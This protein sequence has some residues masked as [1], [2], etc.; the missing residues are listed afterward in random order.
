MDLGEQSR[1]RARAWTVAW[2]AAV[3]LF[4]AYAAT[5]ALTGGAAAEWLGDAVV[6]TGAALAV[7]GALRRRTARA[8]LGLLAA[9]LVLWAAGQVV[10][11]LAYS[12]S[13]APP[14]PSW[15]DACRL[16]CYP[17]YYLSLG[18]LAR[19]RLRRLPRGAWLDGV[20][21]ALT[22]AAFAVGILLRPLRE[23]TGGSLPMVA[24][25][26]A[27]PIGDV[28]LLVLML[29]VVVLGGG[30]PGRVWAFLGAG[31]LLNVAADW[32]FIFTAR[33]GGWADVVFAAAVLCL[34]AATWQ[35][36]TPAARTVTAGWGAV[37]GPIIAM[38][39]ALSLLGSWAILPGAHFAA[40]IPAYAAALLGLGRTMLTVRE[41]LQLVESRREALTDELTGLANRRRLLR[42]LDA[43]LAAPGGACTLMLVD[44]DGFKALNDSLGHAAGDRVLAV[45][46]ARLRRAV[47]ESGLVARLGGDEFAVLLAG[48]GDA[49]PVAQALH[50]AIARPLPLAGGPAVGASIGL[51]SAPAHGDHP[52]TL[53]R[54]ADLAMYAAKRTGAATAVAQRAPAGTM[55]PELRRALDHGELE[56][57]VQPQARLAD[58]AV[59]GVEALI[60]WR[61]PERGLLAPAAFLTAVREAGLM[62]RLTGRVLEAALHHARAWAQDGT[63]IPISVNVSAEDVLDPDFPGHVRRLLDDAG[64]PP[65]LLRLEITE[66][67]L[68]ADPERANDGLAA[69]RRAGVEVGLDDFGTGYSSLAALRWL[70][71]DELKIDRSFVRELAGGG[72]DASIV[73]ATL[74]LARTFGLRVVA[75]GIED[76]ATWDAL[77]RLG[78][79]VGQGYWLARPMP[80][81][82]LPRWLVAR[83][84]VSDAGRR[85]PAATTPRPGAR[86]A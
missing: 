82:E 53:L 74:A 65:A 85:R 77:A 59:G 45:V 67:A 27:Y 83:A 48:P 38:A 3:L 43:A 33:A 32:S 37:A 80:A 47:G 6:V 10:W 13:A 78:C 75:E 71:L 63:P 69:L 76:E 30:R 11:T 58:H 60:R 24:T 21:A 2:G 40:A 50:A 81:D 4:A 42:A 61:H 28:V 1:A 22:L 62:R 70:E 16:G 86:V 19:D 20:I 26:L 39:G 17:L 34:A 9:A 55:A 64:L 52:S 14:Y 25:T 49:E 7:A 54:E 23:S 31:M 41:N 8:G 66:T 36:V 15:S 68:M 35:P 5:A 79:D 46:G 56:L 84:L 51:A 72:P 73:R 44:L 57:Y 12:R 18:L 29:P